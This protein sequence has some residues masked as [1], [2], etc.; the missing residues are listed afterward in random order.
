VVTLPQARVEEYLKLK[1]KKLPL[2]AMG[3]RLPVSWLIC[4]RRSDE[5]QPTMVVERKV[6]AYSRGAPECPLSRDR[7]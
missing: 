4:M 1:G 7:Q 5:C 6:S 3:K 2:H